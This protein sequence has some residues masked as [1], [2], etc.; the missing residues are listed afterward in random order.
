LKQ[1]QLNKILRIKVAQA[2]DAGVAAAKPR[3]VNR[4]RPRQTSKEAVSGNP[5]TASSRSEECGI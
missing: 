4:Q 1:L 3:R 2:A 5:D